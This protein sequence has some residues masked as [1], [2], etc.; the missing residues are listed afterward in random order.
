LYAR[1]R[2]GRFTF[3]DTWIPPQYDTV[4]GTNQPNINTADVKVQGSGGLYSGN[5]GTAVTKA[6]DRQKVL[7]SIDDLI[8]AAFSVLDTYGAAD[9][10]L[11]IYKSD[12]G[13]YFG[14]H[15]VWD[16]KDSFEDPAI[17]IPWIMNGPGFSSDTQLTAPIFNIDLFP[18]ICRVLNIYPDW[19]IDNGYAIQ[20]IMS[21]AVDVSNR[22]VPTCNGKEVP[23][24]STSFGVMVGDKYK[25]HYTTNRL[26]DLQAD[27]WELTD[28]HTNPAYAT[29]LSDL[30]TLRTS[31]KT[32]SGPSCFVTYP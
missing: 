24:D 20:D 4:A 3:Y 12:N 25:L 19:V 6:R 18:T 11:I 30:Q 21:G 31:Q 23:A 13:F 28:V 8:A 22:V 1:N 15:D 26:Y 14:E 29:V 17:R 27:P 16:G 5:P 9:D 7:C 10:T 32:C 2:T